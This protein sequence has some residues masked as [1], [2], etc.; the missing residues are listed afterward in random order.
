MQSAERTDARRR[1][2]GHERATW[3]K[4]YVRRYNAGDSIR[5]IASDTGRSYGFVHRLL[6]EGSVQLRK[7]GGARRRRSHSQVKT[8]T[9]PPAGQTA[10]ADTIT[11][12]ATV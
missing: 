4:D 3:V 10:Q 12:K 2:V 8:F 11:R 6:V 9:H 7:R 5:K 1:I